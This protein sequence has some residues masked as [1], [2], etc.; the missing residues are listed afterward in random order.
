MGNTKDEL[1]KR[2]IDHFG[3]TDYCQ[4]AG[5]ILDDGSMLDFSGKS[6]GAP[7]G[8]RWRDHRE[9]TFIFDIEVEQQLETLDRTDLMTLFME[10]TNAIRYSM[11]KTKRG[12]Y[13]LIIDLETFHSP[14]RQQQRRLEQCCLDNPDRNIIYDIYGKNGRILISE[15]ID[16]ANCRLLDDMIELLEEKKQEEE[17]EEQ[18]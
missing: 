13:D 5:F 18:E 4:E 15:A 7:A 1:I 11:N 10:R 17:Q 8:T 6:E 16:S 14:T 2:A 9:I 3:L 12:T